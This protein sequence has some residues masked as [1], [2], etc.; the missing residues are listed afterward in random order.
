MY[1]GWMVGQCAYAYVQTLTEPMLTAMV[2]LYIGIG[3]D[4]KR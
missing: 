4:A 3:F 2:V 1:N